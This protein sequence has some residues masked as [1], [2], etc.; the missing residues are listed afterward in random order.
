MGKDI[1]ENRDIGLGAVEVVT[2]CSI[3]PYWAGPVGVGGN[4]NS[5]SGIGFCIILHHAGAITSR[6][7][8]G[9]Y[10]GAVNGDICHH[11]FTFGEG[12]HI[13]HA[14]RR[15]ALVYGAVMGCLEKKRLMERQP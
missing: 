12:E 14:P 6:R 10:I 15:P 4:L 9:G 13:L 11:R 2:A 8:P 7:S 1:G 5:G 3:P